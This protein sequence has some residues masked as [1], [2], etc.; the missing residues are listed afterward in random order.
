MAWDADVSNSG[1]AAKS[2]IAIV[3]KADLSAM[4][5]SAREKSFKKYQ[6]EV[7]VNQEYRQQLFD[8]QETTDDHLMH[9][10]GVL[11]EKNSGLFYI[12]ENSWGENSENKGYVYVSDA[13]LRLNSISFTLPKEAIPG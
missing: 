8:S 13:Y 6:P 4:S 10:V 11:D 3:P 2:G 5:A 1:F 9:I 7:A 12:T